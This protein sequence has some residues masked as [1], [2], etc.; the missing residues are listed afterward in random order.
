MGKNV[1]V[2]DKICKEWMSQTF[3]KVCPDYDTCT[4]RKPIGVSHAYLIKDSIRDLGSEAIMSKMWG[5][6][7]RLH[8]MEEAQS[9]L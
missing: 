3:H 9:K 2:C 8:E 5:K 6:D 7:Q 4:K 1:V